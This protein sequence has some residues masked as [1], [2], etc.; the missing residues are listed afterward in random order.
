MD[1]E[2]AP[3]PTAVA[4]PP[5]RPSS[6]AAETRPSETVATTIGNRQGW[7]FDDM[8]TWTEAE[9][10]S[11]RKM[12]HD[13]WQGRP[14]DRGG[15]GG[16][17][18]ERAA[19]NASVDLTSGGSAD[20]ASHQRLR[21]PAHPPTRR[22]A[23]DLADK[24]AAKK[25]PSAKKAPKQPIPKQVI[26]DSEDTHESLT[27]GPQQAE[28]AL[29]N[30]ASETFADVLRHQSDP[31][32]EPLGS[33][34]LKNPNYGVV[35][36]DHFCGAGSAAHGLHVANL[37]PDF[38]IAT[39]SNPQCRQTYRTHWP[40]AAVFNQFDHMSP[41]R[42]K[43]IIKATFAPL[44]QERLD[45]R[46]KERRYQLEENE[47][48]SFELNP[49]ITIVVAA[50]PPCPPISRVRGKAAA[51]A[52]DIDSTLLA[53]T[54]EWVQKLRD[55][56]PS[57]FSVWPLIETVIPSNHGVAEKLQAL[58]NNLYMTDAICIEGS[59]D[60][61]YG[62]VETYILDPCYRE[63]PA[64]KPS[65]WDDLVFY[66][67]PRIFW[68]RAPLDV[69]RDGTVEK[70]RQINVAPG[71]SVKA[72]PITPHAAVCHGD[73]EIDGWRLHKCT[74][75]RTNVDENGKHADPRT[76]TCLTTPAPDGL[77]REIP[78]GRSEV[79][80]NKLSIERWRSHGKCYAPWAYDEANLTWKWTAENGWQWR[81]LNPEQRETLHAL[82]QGFTRYGTTKGEIIEHPWRV[83][84]TM[85]ANGWHADA[86][87]KAGDA[88]VACLNKEIFR[89]VNEDRRRNGCNRTDAHTKSSVVSAVNDTLAG[90]PQG[91]TNSELCILQAEPNSLGGSWLDRVAT[92]AR[93]NI[94]SFISHPLPARI[95]DRRVLVDTDPPI[96]ASIALATIHP[97]RQQWQLDSTLLFA[98]ELIAKWRHEIPR[99]RRLILDDIVGLGTDLSDDFDKW[100][101]GL[102]SDTKEAYGSSPIHVPLLGH[103]LQS[104]GYP[105][106]DAIVEGCTHGFALAGHI[107]AG[108]GWPPKIS[109]S[110]PLSE[111]EFRE[112]NDEYVT[113]QMKNRKPSRHADALL[114]EIEAERAVGRMRGPFQAPPKW[115]TLTVDPSSGG[116]V[117]RPD[118]LLA[119][120]AD[121]DCFPSI[122]FP[123]EQIGAD[124]ANKIRRGEDWLRSGHNSL[125]QTDS[126]P[127]HYNIDHQVACVKALVDADLPTPKTWGQDHE[128]AYR[129][130][131]ARP[132]HLL[133]VL[134]RSS[135]GWSLWQHLVALF[136][137]KAAV[138]IYNRFA[139]A[140]MHIARAL[141]LIP[142]FHYVDDFTGVD[143]APFADSGFETFELLSE[144]LN[145]KLK[146]SKRQ[147]PAS[148][149][150]E[151][152]VIFEVR[153]AL[154]RV[155][156]RP[157]R[158]DRIKTFILK[159]L[160][161]D[162][163]P[164]PKA[165]KLA[166]ELNF[167]FTAVFGNLGAAALKP[168]YGQATYKRPKLNIG[169]RAALESL[170]FLLDSAPPREIPLRIPERCRN[171]LY[172][173]AYFTKGSDTVRCAE[174]AATGYDDK[175]ILEFT[176]NGWGAIVVRQD[177]TAIC[178][179]GSV[180]IDTL[181]RLKA[182]KTHV[183]FLEVLGQCFG[184]WLFA[185]ELGDVYWAFV[186]NV[187]A[188]C[189]L[190][191][192]YSKN[193]DGNLLV[194]LFWH[195]SALRRTYPWFEHVP[196]AAQLADGVSRDD[197]SIPSQRGW[198]YI[199]PDFSPFW[200]LLNEI[201]DS[202]K[203]ATMEHVRRLEAWVQTQRATHPPVTVGLLRAVRERGR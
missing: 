184:A 7:K 144:T 196:S 132:L 73:F 43:R 9:R 54:F 4:D 93:S 119:P 10:A 88:L 84:A 181:A 197:W 72:V 140:V 173:D 8:S 59:D 12:T 111:A 135:E 89:H 107:V 16:K 29:Q 68:S 28:V 158:R 141:L 148:A 152:G 85:I 182:K 164:G 42:A 194:S 13:P 130:L 150:D 149:R 143:P 95:A 161:E 33:Y 114:A 51:Q 128:G 159:C 171:L 174:L 167:Y 92:L 112:M 83:R 57:M 123:I 191:K 30:G 151:L 37:E 66:S 147:I 69:S 46:E 58:A 49:F 193:A 117:G 44:I 6:A 203:L 131:P 120:P 113:H 169:L 146:R 34:D 26:S 134:L 64:T 179:R 153:D 104:F 175:R 40:Q 133:W 165:E 127:V 108:V 65:Y 41:E 52:Q 50:G 23:A 202:G 124:G 35:L 129:Q 74:S 17:Y 97:L 115:G 195:H 1:G 15:R 183:F 100:Y 157:S 24:V 62:K 126:K 91:R 25:A 27:V 105:D 80:F 101:D 20:D 142:T 78:P 138:W 39:D 176:S 187:G 168:I 106:A 201:L 5:P 55:I 38:V 172:A 11:W 21:P 45:L 82:P 170:V 200:T 98:V 121:T 166:G 186:D 32:K 156:P 14:R 163:L 189:S 118:G 136:G 71:L 18:R 77:G 67:R 116:P 139:D 137:S 31:F 145:V 185:E 199:D 87:V 180:P 178:V 155:K 125:A 75:R 47:P 102:G 160:D 63:E 3:S 192:G 79:H 109:G 56:L 60:V 70:G 81:P 36:I 76:M 177:A 61:L 188:R 2:G 53:R 110:S 103:L 96:H 198:E 154:V 22:S 190:L 19:R 122:A 162:S 94:H 48:P 90:A 86:A 99:L